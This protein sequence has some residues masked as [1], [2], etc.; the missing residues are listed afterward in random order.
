M[1]ATN[2]FSWHSNGYTATIPAS[3]F[4]YRGSIAMAR[5]DATAGL[6]HSIRLVHNFGHSQSKA[7]T[8][9]EI[10]VFL[11]V[12]TNPARRTHRVS[13]HVVSA[14]AVVIYNRADTARTVAVKCVAMHSLQE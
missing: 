1:A 10:L 9:N 6:A 7:F 11:E 12:N 2:M 13:Y 5:S 4:A 14:D 8:V 3:L